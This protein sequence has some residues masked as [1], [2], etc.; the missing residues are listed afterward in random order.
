MARMF[1]FVQTKQLDDE[2]VSTVLFYCGSV[3]SITEM[4]GT[5][6]YSAVDK[7]RLCGREESS[8]VITGTEL[9]TE[10]QP[11]RP[12]SSSNISSNSETQQDSCCSHRH[13]RRLSHCNGCG[14]FEIKGTIFDILHRVWPVIRVIMSLQLQ[15]WN[16]SLRIFMNSSIVKTVDNRHWASQCILLYGLG[17]SRLSTV[18]DVLAIR[19]CHSC[20]TSR[21]EKI[22]RRLDVE[23]KFH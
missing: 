15:I 14:N 22:G 13:L 8:S 20:V 7:S 6:S 18:G 5:L 23:L 21:I 12:T 16:R 10:N 17:Q 9:S 1:G 3:L 4:V 11:P 2:A 19:G